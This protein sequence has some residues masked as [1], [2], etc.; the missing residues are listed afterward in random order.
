VTVKDGKNILTENTDYYV[1]YENCG[2]I[3][4]ASVKITGCGNY[5]GV[6]SKTYKITGIA[7]NSKMFR[8]LDGFIYNGSKNSVYQGINYLT[9]YKGASLVEGID[10][11]VSYSGDRVNV[12]KFKV[13]FKGINNYTGS[14]TKTYTIAKANVADTEL[15]FN[16]DTPYPYSKNGTKPR[17]VIQFNGKLLTEGKD[18][19]VSYVNNTKVA[20]KEDK[21]APY[22]YIT[23]MGNFAGNT[24][25]TPVKFS[26]EESQINLTANIEVKDILFKNSKNNYIPS[27]V[28]TDRYSGK[29]LIKKSDYDA[30]FKY[31]IYD[32]NLEKYKELETNQVTESDFSGKD[33][34][35][36]RVTVSGIK[37]YSGTISE[38]Y[39]IYKKNIATVM[40]DRIPDQIY[41][42]KAIEPEIIIYEKVKSGVYYP[43]HPLNYDVEYENNINKGTATVYIYGDREYGGVKKVTFKI[44]SQHM[45]WWNIWDN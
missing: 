8:Q 41:T 23:G 27:V 45:Q 13:T 1:S 3:G 26:I 22:L 14:V 44:T 24:K 5:T 29:K 9:E 18:Y 36:M 38:Y 42:G 11:T 10:Y 30:A 17:T 12:G 34:I 15:I 37:N 7:L 43:I 32:S 39:E 20:S 28:L 40:V 35:Y 33:R 6:K 25:N 16:N 19:K 2:K 31:E 4:N 21:E